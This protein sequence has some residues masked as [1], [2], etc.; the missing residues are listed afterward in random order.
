MDKA[1]KIKRLRS[2]LAQG[3]GVL[4]LGPLFS[5]QLDCL[6]T[7]EFINE[8][9]A[10]ISDGSSWDGMD[11]HD[12]FRLVETDL[13]GDRLRNELAEYFPSDEMLID[14]VKP[15]QKQLLSLPFSTVIDLDLHN[16]TNAVLRSINQKFRYICS[17]SDLV[18][19][20]QN[21]PGEKDVIKVRGDLWVDESSVT[22]DGVKQRLTQNPGVK[23]FIEKSFGDGPVILYGFDPNDPVLRWITETFAPLSGTSFLCTRLS[24]KLW[25]TYWK[26]KGFQVLIAATI[27]ELEAVVSEL[28]ESI[29]PKSDLPDIHAML[30]EVGDVVARQLA[31]VDLLQWVRRPKA[32]LDELTSSEL[33]SVARSIQ[34]MALLNEHG[35]PIPARPAAYAAEVSIGAGDLPA[36]RQAL[37]LA[38]HSISNQKRFD[39]IAMAAVGR[40]LIRLGDTH[41]ARLYLQSALHANETDPRAQADDFAWLSRSVLKKIDLLKARGRR[42]AVI[43]L[44]A[45]FLKDQAPY[46]YLTQEQTDDAEFSRSIYYINLRL[47]RLMALASEMAE[48]STRVYE[49]QAVKLLTRAI[50]MVPGKPDGYK[51][52]RPLLT[53]RKYSTVDSKLWMTLVASAPPAVQ[54][55]LGGR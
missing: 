1:S 13:G 9:S 22:I 4:V 18:S 55:R 11:L 17:D 7:D 30:D 10:R 5:R 8:M 28:C 40:T 24:N 14:Q 6:G 51:A 32:E 19:Q 48:Q 27:P 29:Q 31:S 36:A 54:R 52:I 49:Q 2:A 33:N 20:S 38:V 12:R 26:N 16:L 39:H 46:V 25:S 41:R 47:G 53:D 15:F 35:L 43:E 44:V 3:R 34:M 45:G 23:R 37:E 50:E 42:R 21:L